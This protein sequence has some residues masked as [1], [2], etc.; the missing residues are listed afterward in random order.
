MKAT[1]PMTAIPPATDMPMIDPVLRLLLLLGG[2]LG[3]ELDETAEE[4]ELV[5]VTVGRMPLGPGEVG[6]AVFGAE[7]VASG[8]E[9]V[10]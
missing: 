1:I 3:G 5:T 2:T 9:A 8:E 7:V 4:L 6:T 10:F